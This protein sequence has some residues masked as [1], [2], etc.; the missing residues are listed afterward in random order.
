M[1]LNPVFQFSTR[2]VAMIGIAAI[3]AFGL[4]LFLPSGSPT[5]WNGSGNAAL[6]PSLAIDGT[7]EVTSADN[8][9]TRLV[10]PLTLRGDDGIVLTEGGRLHAQTL[11]SETASAAVPAIYAVT[12]SDGNGDETL[13]PGEHAVLTVDLPVPSSVHPGNPVDI[14]IRPIGSMPLVI[15]DVVR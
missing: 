14:V 9:V 6:P 13:D 12:W 4:W 10:V 7:V 3:T 1:T 8:V 15:E 5:A 2:T 11:L